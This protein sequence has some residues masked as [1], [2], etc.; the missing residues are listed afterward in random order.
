[1]QSIKFFTAT[2]AALIAARCMAADADVKSQVLTSTPGLKEIV[3]AVRKPGHDGHWYANFGY[4]GTDENRA[5]YLPGGRLCKL[6]IATG[7]VRALIDDPQ[8]GVRD[9]VLNHDATRILFSWRKG[10]DPYYH[11]HDCKLDGSEIRKLTDG[12]WNDIEPCILPDGDIVFV[13]S[14]AKRWVNCWLTQ[15]ATLH[16]CK[17]DGTG[18]HPISANIEHD[19]TPWPLPDGRI[20]YQRWEYIDRSQVHYHHLWS[21]NPDGT[22][23]MPYF[24]N[25]NRNILMIDAK[26]IPGTD[27]IVTLFS[28]GHGQK[29]HAGQVVVLNPRLGPDDTSAIR[30]IHPNKQ[31]RDPWPLTREAFLAARD[32]EILAMDAKGGLQPVFS[33]SEEDRKAGFWVHEP[34]PVIARAREIVIPLAP[35]RP[36]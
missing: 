36:N 17:A 7:A 28:P 25:Q 32:A 9:P 24:G 18:I 14:R 5:A 23:P 4:Y 2:I 21:A 1:M 35:I 33:L 19:N 29:E 16:R 12:P 3:F 11:L 10:D 27:E 6:D 20:L 8:G 22:N 13:S 31:I 26:P 34:R 15:V 30:V